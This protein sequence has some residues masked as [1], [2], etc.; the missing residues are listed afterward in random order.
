[1]QISSRTSCPLFASPAKKY[2]KNSIALYGVRI[3]EFHFQL[4]FVIRL[5]WSINFRD[6]HGS[7]RRM[8][9]LSLTSMPYTSKVPYCVRFYLTDTEQDSYKN[10][11]K[12]RIFAFI[13]MVYSQSHKEQFKS[14]GGIAWR[15][16]SQRRCKGVSPVEALC[17]LQKLRGASRLRSSGHFN[18][19]ATGGRGSEVWTWKKLALR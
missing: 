7:S 14:S 13:S 11:R 3:Y 18:Y 8:L 6:Y 17:H 12:S 5:D 16:K 4:F 2:L 9:V 1:M 19:S 15:K 10:I